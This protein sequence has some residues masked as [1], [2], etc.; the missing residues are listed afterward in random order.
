MKNAILLFAA[1]L[2]INVCSR[3]TETGVPPDVK[4]SLLLDKQEYFLGENI[5]I[6]YCIKNEGNEPVS[7]DVGGDYR[8]GTRAS[9]FKV[10]ATG[11]DRKPAADP[12]PVQWQMGGMSPIASIKKDE[13]WYG[14]FTRHAIA[15]LTSRATIRFA[16][17]TILAGEKKVRMT[18]APL[19]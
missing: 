12:D 4:I 2:A 6:N 17:I 19:P 14:M 16:F 7:I 15:V 11:P 1:V 8:G 18:F 10:T 13:V 5:L 3:D 9:R